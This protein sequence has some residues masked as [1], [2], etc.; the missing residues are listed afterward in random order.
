MRQLLPKIITIS[1]WETIILKNVWE[2]TYSKRTQKHI[3]ILT[4]PASCFELQSVVIAATPIEFSVK[5]QVSER[6]FLVTL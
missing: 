1:F 2:L 3:K 6:P 4:F 5:V